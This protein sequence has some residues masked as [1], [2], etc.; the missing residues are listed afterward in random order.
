MPQAHGGP[1]AGISIVLLAI[2]AAWAAGLLPGSPSYSHQSLLDF[3]RTVVA[4]LATAA[5]G[6]AALLHRTARKPRRMYIYDRSPT[7]YD[8]FVLDGDRW[9]EWRFK[10][11][12]RVGWLSVRHPALLL[13]HACL[14][15]APPAHP[16]SVSTL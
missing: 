11:H 9:P 14:L 8:E 5:A 12:F 16:A 6:Q 3:Q 7:W 15:C 10:Q 1:Q 2:A 4:A 13:T